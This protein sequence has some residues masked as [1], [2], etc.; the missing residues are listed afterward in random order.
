LPPEEVVDAALVGLRHHGIAP[1][2]IETRAAEGLSET[3][4]TAFDTT[5]WVV[6]PAEG[7]A[8]ISAMIGRGIALRVPLLAVPNELVVPS[9]DGD[10]FSIAADPVL[11]FAAALWA[12]CH[13]GL[14][15][16]RPGVNRFLSLNWFRYIVTKGCDQGS[17]GEA[18]LTG[19]ERV[20]LTP[21]THSPW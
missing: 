10:R 13:G 11:H 15:S 16:L 8:A 18:E 14:P 4:G 2:L 7:R 19:M 17:Q 21:G 1:R 12:D 3:D 5:A 20:A 6:D 9:E